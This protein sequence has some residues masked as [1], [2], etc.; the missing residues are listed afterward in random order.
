M[1][2]DAAA[3]AASSS[4]TLRSDNLRGRAGIHVD[5][6][7]NRRIVRRIAER[8]GLTAMQDRD[9]VRVRRGQSAI[10]SRKGRE[11]REPSKLGVPAEDLFRA[12]IY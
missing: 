10:V 7:R 6:Y 9:I 1:V 8:I 3:K 4:L 5:R 2:L 11:R 12:R